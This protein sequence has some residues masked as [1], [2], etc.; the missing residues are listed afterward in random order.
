MPISSGDRLSS[1]SLELTNELEVF[2]KK[3]CDEKKISNAEI[4]KVL[5]CETLKHLARN[6][7]LRV[8][9]EPSGTQVTEGLEISLHV[10]QDGSVNHDPEKNKKEDIFFIP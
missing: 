5:D 8:S 3:F 2:I 6:L 9:V 1:A 10:R 4:P 7:G